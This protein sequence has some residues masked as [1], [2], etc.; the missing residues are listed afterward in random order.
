MAMSKW[1]SSLQFRLILA[2]TAILALTLGSVSAYVAFASQREVERFDSRFREAQTRRLERFIAT[3]RDHQRVG[4]LQPTLE[5]AGA[6]FGRRIIVRDPTGEIV[7][8][9]GSGHGGPWVPGRA[10]A[11]MSLPLDIGEREEG[12]ILIAAGNIPGTFPDPPVAQV[13]SALNRSLIWTGLAAVAAGIVLLSFVSRRILVPVR[14]LSSAAQRVGRGDLCQRV[15]SSGPSEIGQLARTFNTMAEN[16]ENAERQRRNLTADV[17]HELRT[18]VSNIQGYLEAIRDGLLEPDDTIP[19]ILHQ[20]LQLST[21]IEDLRLL[22]L[23]EAGQLRLDLEPSV[24]EELL[25]DLVRAT[26]P[27]AESKGVSLKLDLPQR[28]AEV[29]IDRTRI[30]QV[31]GNLLDNAISHTPEGGSVTVS[32]SSDR[33]LV[34]VTV[35]DTGEGI[36]PELLPSVFDRFYRGDPSRTRATGGTGLGL[37]ISKHLIEAHYGSIRAESTP[38]QGS[39]FIFELPL[40]KS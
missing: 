19:V 40:A 11:E 14:S 13:T 5:E 12:S 4:G 10:K 30:G 18:P 2:F 7:G 17:A 33:D 21:L 1:F 28:G 16:L 15:P 29:Q 35:A 39:R 32:S 6:L 3:Y 27:Q 26:Q 37:T 31:L 20:V 24:L 38:G 36:P 8:D 22:L 25:R 34:R 9:S 23:A